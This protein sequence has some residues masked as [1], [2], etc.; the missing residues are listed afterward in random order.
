MTE[1]AS[2][3]QIIFGVIAEMTPEDAA[4]SLEAHFFR[5]MVAHARHSSARG[6]ARC[7][8]LV[9]EY[10]RVIA[11]GNGGNGLTKL[12]AVFEEMTS[13]MSLEDDLRNV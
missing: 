5:E 2:L 4:N 1:A 12:E 7:T 8:E 9:G 6:C 10:E 13:H 3:R 11:G